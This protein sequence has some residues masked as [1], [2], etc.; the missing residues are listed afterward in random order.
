[1]SITFV[2][3]AHALTEFESSLS[4]LQSIGSAQSEVN[5]T[6]SGLNR[7][8][9]TFSI[10][11]DTLASTGFFSHIGADVLLD[12]SQPDYSKVFIQNRDGQ[13]VSVG[14]PSHRSFE[15]LSG[16]GLNYFISD[17]Q[18]AI[19]WN[20][21]LTQTPYSLS[22]FGF[23][24]TQT[25]F[26]KTTVL[27]LSAQYGTQTQP[28]S[29]FTTVGFQT[30]QRP[31][32][33]HSFALNAS[34]EQILTDR[35]K[36][37]VSAFSGRRIEERPR[38]VGFE[39][40]QKLAVLDTLYAGLNVYHL[41]EN[42]SMSLQ[43]ER[44]HFQIWSATVSLTQEIDYDWLVTASYGVAIENEIDLR[45]NFETT[46]GSDQYGLGVSYQ[47]SFGKVFSEASYLL[48]ATGSEQVS[49]SG[50]VVWTL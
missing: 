43:N 41:V 39:V 44:G 42:Q 46:Q 6:L 27:S 5:G 8:S 2:P 19:S 12:V 18:F 7:L 47:A 31:E 38:H 20:G 29:Y 22:Q 36:A 25:F 33:V 16:L 4:Y 30:R 26:E 23:G 24:Y 50:G 15:L 21:H 1:M 45:R 37:K 48:S 13:Y 32:S 49:L 17:S 3:S 34:V 11:S 28:L 14:Q 40:A 35:W 9:Q 10:S